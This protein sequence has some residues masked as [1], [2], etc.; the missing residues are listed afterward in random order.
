MNEQS[1][2]LSAL[3]T[4]AQILCQVKG[5]RQEEIIRQL[6]E[7]IATADDSIDSE[8][9]FE[10]IHSRHG[11]GVV[12]LMS[13]VATVHVRINGLH[14]LHMALATSRG[15][16]I[17]C[18]EREDSVCATPDAGPANLIALM[19]VPDDD[20]AIY[21]RAIAALTTVC[22]QEGFLQTL[23]AA[24]DAQTVWQ[25][26]ADNGVEIPEYVAARHMMRTDFPTLSNA[27][28]LDAA[29]DLFCRKGINEVPIVDSDGDLVGIVSE[30]ELIRMCL[31]EYIT[32]MEDLS[33]VLNF[34]PFA[35]IMRREE[36]IPV[37]EIMVFA[38]RYATIDE[39]APAI[40][41]AKIMMR[42]D[43]KQVL[44]VREN[45]LVGVISI[46]DFIHKVL[47]A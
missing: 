18:P 30:D 13:D 12:S 1:A 16:Q 35:E 10:L 25:L 21:L 28:T 46:Q 40:Q 22:R 8:T 36:K 3:F 44:V 42:R 39:D 2:Q 32:W 38:D 27:D 37:M 9:V 7:S 34:E 41:V 20:P 5:D 15:G 11:C 45:K 43:V 26:F 14:Q 23:L 17:C 33:P 24:E 4:P 31:P 6:I 19:L 29:I 47:R